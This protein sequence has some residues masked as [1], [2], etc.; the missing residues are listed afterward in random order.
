MP[1]KHPKKSMWSIPTHSFSASRPRTVEATEPVGT[2]GPRHIQMVLDEATMQQAKS[3]S[4]ARRISDDDEVGKAAA[5]KFYLD[6]KKARRSN[7]Q[8][9]L[10]NTGNP[11]ILGNVI[12]A[13][14]LSAGVGFE[15]YQRHLQGQLSWEVVGLGAGVL[16]LTAGVDYVISRWLLRNKFPTK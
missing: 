11:V 7:L 10:D 8:V 12:L 6:G 9:V 4:E 2:E 16:G 14:V 13:T 1:V 5:K 3:R 15:A